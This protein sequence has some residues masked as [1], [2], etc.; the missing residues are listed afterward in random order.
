MLSKV[1][2]TLKMKNIF[3]DVLLLQINHDKNKTMVVSKENVST[4]IIFELNGHVDSILT[5]IF[6]PIF[7]EI[8]G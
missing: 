8:L 5:K 1:V 7:N 3:N 4:I 2:F 6:Q